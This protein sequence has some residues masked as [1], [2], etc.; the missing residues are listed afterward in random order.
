ML[1]MCRKLGYTLGRNPGDQMLTR[2]TLKL[3]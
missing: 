1:E 2:V 3:A